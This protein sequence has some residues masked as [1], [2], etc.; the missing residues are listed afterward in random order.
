MVKKSL[1]KYHL[2]FFTQ[3]Q[4]KYFDKYFFKKRS[5]LAESLSVTSVCKFQKKMENPCMTLILT[6]KSRYTSW[7][8]LTIKVFK[9]TMKYYSLRIYY[10]IWRML[11]AV[12]LIFC[13]RMVFISIF[14]VCR[15]GYTIGCIINRF[16]TC[17]VSP[18]TS[19]ISK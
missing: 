1:S 14:K 16:W 4:P 8:K 12:T 7:T 11:I 15:S 19:S 6:Y 17:K 13:R 9:K 18:S 3:I 5:I 2:N 10:C